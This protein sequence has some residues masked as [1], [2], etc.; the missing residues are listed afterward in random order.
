MDETSLKPYV[1]N[2]DDRTYAYVSNNWKMDINQQYVS[3]YVAEGVDEQN[4]WWLEDDHVSKLA[5]IVVFF[6]EVCLNE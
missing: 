6:R 3:L 1:D 4:F 2:D 5:L